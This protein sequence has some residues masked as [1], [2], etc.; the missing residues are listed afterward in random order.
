VLGYQR[1]CLHLKGPLHL[2][3]V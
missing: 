1:F 3:T 2:D